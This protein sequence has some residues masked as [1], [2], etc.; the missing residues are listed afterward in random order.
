MPSLL[1]NYEYDIF[2][3]YRHNDNRSGWVTEF[4]N[5]LQEE[6]A[7]TIKEPLTIYFDKN[8]HDGL[9]ETHNVDKSLEGKLKCLIFI[10]I[11]SQ[12]YCDTKS[13]A[14]QHEFV[15]FN[16]TFNGDGAGES[17]LRGSGGVG[18]DI[19]LSNGNVAS[20]IL[21]IKIHDLD[22]EDKSLIENEI[23]GVLRAIDFIFK[24]AGVNRPLRS[25]EDHP[26]DN[27]NKTFYRDQV[28]KVANAVKEIISALKNPSATPSIVTRNKQ[29]ITGNNQK[30]TRKKALII[31]LAVLLIAVTSYFFYQQP[32][33]R[34]GRR[35]TTNDQ[36]TP[37]DKSIAVLP[38][39]N[40]SG[41]AAQE[42]FSD[43]ISE[44]IL[45]SLA[46]IEG[47]KVTGRTSSFQ[48]K[49]KGMDL[50]E[51]GEKLSVAT[52]LEGSI[53]KQ[54][55]RLR[56]TVQLVSTK[57]GYQLWSERFDRKIT[58]V[59]AIQDEIAQ[60][61]SS[62]L[63]LTLL[64]PRDGE[65]SA[66]S[67]SK[68]AYDIYLQGRFFLNKRGPGMQKGLEL[69]KEAF[70]IDSTFA[71]TCEGAAYSYALLAFYDYIPSM[72]GIDEAKKWAFEAIQIEPNSEEAF[73]VLGLSALY[74]E[75]DWEKA[76]E[77]IQ[78][79]LTVNSSDKFESATISTYANYLM[80]VEADWVEAEKQLSKQLEHDPFYFLSYLNSG[81]LSLCQRKYNLA[82]S[83]Y[84]KAIEVNG[85]S[86]LP[87]TFLSFAYLLTDQAPKAI[88][89]L[90]NNMTI[91]GRTQGMLASLCEAYAELGNKT[92]A[93]EIYDEVQ[94]LK[95]VSNVSPLTLGRLAISLGKIDEAYQYFDLAI[96]QKNQGFFTWKYFPWNDLK[97]RAAFGKDTRYKKLMDRLAFPKR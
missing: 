58:D 75:S 20:R 14:W 37:L 29:P 54:N 92:K 34:T 4:V 6:L 59:F 48:F 50:K 94:R 32:A 79:S 36:L 56:I 85:N 88:E 35:S 23:G 27:A 46:Q 95:N 77:W 72:Q 66:K 51:V 38:F 70:A 52:I 10:P 68:E 81:H 28:N 91:T 18:R 11:I 93:Q 1:P 65:A 39:E 44:E 31:S 84:Q 76:N 62:K 25:H 15:A 61:V 53:R 8:P 67:T 9:L 30:P 5:A 87:F 21:P 41:D 71:P 43:G 83:A 42:Y 26:Q 55:D 78:K 60:A 33:Y 45:N 16:R 3:S 86:S 47:L 64:K 12:T 89:L 24:S 74:L 19:K 69:F 7:S 49:G 63:K 90:E 13:F 2:I 57:D 96:D 97:I 22:A 40:M 82:I 17:P 80:F 73:A